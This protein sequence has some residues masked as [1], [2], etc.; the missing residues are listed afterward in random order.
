MERVII[1][2]IVVVIVIGV[3]VIFSQAVVIIVDGL[4]SRHLLWDTLDEAVVAFRWLGGG[5]HCSLWCGG[6]DFPRN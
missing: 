5:C 6:G 4:Q 3:C 2:V 1:I